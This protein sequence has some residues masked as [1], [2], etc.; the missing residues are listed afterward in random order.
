[1]HAVHVAYSMFLSASVMSSHRALVAPR[2]AFIRTTL[3]SFWL[4]N[5]R[6]DYQHF[7]AL[8]CYDLA[9]CGL[10]LTPDGPNFG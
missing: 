5:C 8:I 7:V 2:G 3:N 1:M 6:P 4:I 10:N 9:A